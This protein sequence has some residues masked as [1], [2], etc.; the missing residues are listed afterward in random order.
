MDV[1]NKAATE[2]GIPRKMLQAAVVTIPK[3]DNNPSMPE[4]YCP[5]KLNTDVKIFS[6]ALAHRLNCVLH[7]VIHP[8]QEGFV[9]GLK[10]LDGKR[11]VLNVLGATEPCRIP[12]LLLS[13]NAEKTFDR[14]H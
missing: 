9:L 7:L 11:R 12:S 2:G 6:K 8:D 13:L 4:S 10:A 14:V 5:I 3:S 1:F